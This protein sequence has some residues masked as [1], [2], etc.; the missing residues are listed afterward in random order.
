MQIR[1]QEL[2][3]LVLIFLR[4]AKS[5]FLDPFAHIVN[6]LL[7]DRHGSGHFVLNAT[8][9]DVSVK[10]ENGALR[11]LR[12]FQKSSFQSGRG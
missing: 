3:L 5:E 1:T 9:E 6:D 4:N 12:R 8:C 2:L 7:L 11:S 10:V